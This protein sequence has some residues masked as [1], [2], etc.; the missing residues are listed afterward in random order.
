MKFHV[1][2]TGSNGNAYALVSDSGQKL[3]IEAGVHLDK[4]KQQLNFD[5]SDIKGCLISHEHGDHAQYVRNYA[6]ISRIYS[7]KKTIDKFPVGKMNVG[8]F[9]SMDDKPLKLGEFTVIPFLVIH[10]AA[11]PVGFVILH[12]VAGNIVYIT[13]AAFLP[14][15]VSNFIDHLI[16]EVNYCQEILELNI[17]NGMDPYLANRITATH[18]SLEK[19]VKF[20]EGMNVIPKTITCIH[21]SDTN[22]SEKLIKET[23]MSK[24]GCIVNIARNGDVYNF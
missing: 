15:G 14:D 8:R 10:D 12:P 22:S 18:F 11:H 23:L 5:L 9:Y 13:D 21:L 6:L 16:I 2:G 24:F 7:M 17:E 1:I 4:V 20:I 3:L 19:A